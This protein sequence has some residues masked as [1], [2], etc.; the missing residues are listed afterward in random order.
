MDYF[1]IVPVLDND[2]I[3][4]GEIGKFV[5]MSSLR[6]TSITTTNREVI[7]SVVGAPNESILVKTSFHIFLDK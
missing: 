5:T 2:F 6:F 3:L 4:L 7:V 1:V